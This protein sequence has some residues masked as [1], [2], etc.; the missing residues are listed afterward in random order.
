MNVCDLINRGY[1]PKELPP[2]F[3]TSM[4]SE[5]CLEVHSK[6]DS[7]Y[8]DFKDNKKIKYSCSDYVLFSYPKVGYSR[9]MLSVPN[10]LHQYNLSNSICN[11]WIEIEKIFSSSCLTSS[12]PIY[13]EK[14]IRAFN[15]EKTY[16]EFRER[17]ILGSY[18]CLYQLK[19]D[20]SRYYS[21]IYTHVIPWLIHGKK[22][23]KKNR[24]LS[25]LG[26]LLDSSI[27]NTQSGQTNGIPIG[28]DTSFIIAELIL[29]KIDEMLVNQINLVTT[30]A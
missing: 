17:A 6:W 12:K 19:T 9:R 2:P 26:N 16:K 23:S 22:Q 18:S 4:F 3:T 27:R 25:L 11:N 30:Q 29:C 7:L 10:P 8:K 21:T 24:K 28:P 5:S 15:P 1:F 20:I 14:G 13:S